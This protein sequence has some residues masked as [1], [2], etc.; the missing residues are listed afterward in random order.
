MS[1]NEKKN[2]PQ[3]DPATSSKSNEENNDIISP[4][5]VSRR[6]GTSRVWSTESWGW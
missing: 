2:R 4:M 5:V 1:D 3:D 6:S